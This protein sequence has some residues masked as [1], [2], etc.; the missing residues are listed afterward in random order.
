MESAFDIERVREVMRERKITQKEVASVVGITS[1]S[2]ISNI[3]TGK[4]KVNVEEAARIYRFLGI[5]GPAPIPTA[6]NVPIIGFASASSWRDAVQMPIGS[7]TVPPRAAGPRAFAV[8]LQGDSLDMVV[9]DG[10]YLV[11]DP[12]QKE[13]VAG[14]CYLIQNVEHETTVKCYQRDPARFVPLSR[15]DSHKEIPAADVVQIIGKA[16]WQGGPM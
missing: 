1:Q 8:E 4:R 7:M 6:T 12:D 2:A 11:I 14:K 10:H 9:P 16:V 15:N 3:F 13:L 5:A